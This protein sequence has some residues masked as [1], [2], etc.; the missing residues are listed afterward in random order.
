[1]KIKKL[2]LV[3]SILLIGKTGF[4]DPPT[5][6]PGY[7][8][9]L[10]AVY[11]DEFNGNN[12]DLTKWRKE[13][14]FW[15]GRRPAWFNPASISVGD[16]YMKITN[17]V[18]NQPF[19]GYEIYGGAV[20]SVNENTK[21]AYYECR[22]KASST[23]M[24]TTFWLENR[25]APLPGGCGGDSYSQELDIVETI[26]DATNNPVFATHMKSNTHF[27]WKN[28]S[29][30]NEQ[31]FSRGTTTGP[32]K[33]PNGSNQQSD[34]GFHTYG[35]WWKDANEVTFYLDDQEG[36]TVQFRTDK[37]STPFNRGMFICM[38]TETY[39][40]EQRPTD[41]SLTDPTRN[42]SYYDWVRVWTLVPDDGSPVA[43]TGVSVSPSAVSMNVGETEPLNE[44]VSPSN[45]TNKSV[46]WSSNNTSVATV[47]SNGVVTGVSAGTA[48]ITVTAADGGFTD[49]TT[50]TV[51]NAP[52]GGGISIGNP[53][54]TNAGIDGWKS[55]LV[56]NESETYTNNTGASQT[57]NVDEFVFYANRKADPVTPFVVK[58]NSDNNF[59]VLAVGTSRASSAYNV[60][61]NTV[62]FNT[63]TAKQITLANGE[64][65]APGFLDANA[66]GS[67]G[68][69]GSVIPFDSNSPADEIW[70]SGG[71][72][73]GNSAS[74]SEGAAPTGGL[75]TL[76]N[77][78]R[79][80]RF[81]INLSVDSPGGGS[82]TVTL[83]PI[84]D[85]YTQNGSNNNN[86]LIRV[87][88]TSRARIG[89]LQYDLSG[90]NGSITS[91]QLKMTCNS[92]AGN[93]SLS[94]SAALAN[95]NNWTESN[96][97]GSNAPSSSGTLATKQGPFNPGNTY[98]WDLNT[99]SLSGGGNVSLILTASSGS[100]DVA[101]AS[102]ENSA[103]EPQ[104]VITYNS[105]LA[106]K[107]LKKQEDTYP[108]TSVLRAYP[109]PIT[110]STFTVDLRRYDSDVQV[111]IFDIHGRLLYNKKASPKKLK[112]KSNIFREP[113][114][115]MINVK[116]MS[117][118]ET[119]SLLMTFL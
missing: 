64:T 80:Y 106:S 23:R 118:G 43:V 30:G 63:G 71:S 105:E 56:I 77:L 108:L 75:S 96:V 42:T 116:S 88:N 107:R 14:P 33:A 10:S 82:Q 66:N 9:Q 46:S 92:D 115:Y 4:A 1:M 16:G 48:T 113:G 91:A 34:E 94:I 11:S 87:E 74:V 73:S 12:L 83:S 25:K 101:F 26:G 45:A 32:I 52:P 8:W 114:I 57:L 86:N 104:L 2:I 54:N 50:V 18:L 62:A 38:V 102:K 51:S 110:G 111:R 7:K 31:F 112:L 58:V 49:T 79:N 97:S 119:K 17:G 21:F 36:E 15:N 69:I 53:T 6:P 76:T 61:E 109:N 99:S 22:L 20:T 5:A 65:I 67:G 35:A 37:T 39:T 41:A 90:I 72:A 78:T 44:T 47:N 27:R 70:Y 100:D 28:C 98:T 93:G 68:S 29:G 84:H 117:S 81:R 85:A 55:N 59:T 103:T 24:S 89:Y 60:G 19:D 13:H 3:I 40:W 95:S